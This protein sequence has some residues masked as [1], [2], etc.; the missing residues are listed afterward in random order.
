MIEA[1]MQKKKAEK[2]IEQKEQPLSNFESVQRVTKG[3]MKVWVD[4]FKLEVA[5]FKKNIAPDGA[6]SRPNYIDFDHCHIFHTYN[7]RGK[8]NTHCAAVGG[9]YH[10]VYLKVVDGKFV[11]ETSPPIQNRG[12]EE[13]APKRDGQG[14]VIDN[15]THQVTYLKSDEQGVKQVSPEVAKLYDAIYAVDNTP[16]DKIKINK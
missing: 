9:H 10:E 15:H 6:G 5:K 7:E 12:S 14:R 16:S 13:I 4:T 1:T 2:E 11:G 8:P 3:S